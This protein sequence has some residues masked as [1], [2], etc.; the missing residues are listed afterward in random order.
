M[1]LVGPHFVGGTGALGFLLA[2][3]VVAA[4]AVVS[5]AA[6]IYVARFSN[7]MVSI[8]TIALQALLTVGAM[9]LVDRLGFRRTTAPRRPRRADAVAS[10][11]RRWSRR[12]CSRASSGA[13]QQLALG[14]WC[15]PRRPPIV[16]GELAIQLPEWAE[17]A[18]RHPRDPVR[19]RLGH[20]AARLRA[21][22]TACCSAAR[23]ADAAVGEGL[24]TSG[25]DRYTEGNVHERS[26]FDAN[27]PTRRDRAVVV[28]AGA[29]VAAGRVRAARGS[30]STAR[31]RATRAAGAAR[32]QALIDAAAGRGGRRPAA[33]HAEHR[34]ASARSVAADARPVAPA[35]GHADDL[36]RIKGVGP[37]LASS[38]WRAR[39]HQLCADRRVGRCRD[40]PHRRP[41]RRFQPAASGAT[42]GPRRRGYLAAGDIAGF[43]A[44]LRP[45]LVNAAWGTAR[46][47]IFGNQL[48]AI[49]QVAPESRVHHGMEPAARRTTH[50]SGCRG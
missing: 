18:F 48:R 12:S 39:R 21:R 34:R 19:L 20:L 44:A 47:A 6:L 2:A 13:D 43:E 49:D 1:G 15:G 14:R 26:D 45:T 27:W 10:A 31:H 37:K 35:A 22:R 30:A 8:G 33:A 7:L 24:E 9:L 3:E 38:C 25:Q 41:A 42:T 32:N 50:R 36:T 17:L 5:E 46:F 23:S 40:R 28:V 4:T 16:V 11:P 29:V